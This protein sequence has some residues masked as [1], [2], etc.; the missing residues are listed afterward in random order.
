MPRAGRLPLLAATHVA[1]DLY[2]GAVPALAPYF[3]SQ[4]HYGYAAVGGVLLAGTL[5]ACVLM[6]TFGM[7]SDRYG[8][9]WMLPVG[10]LAAGLGFGLC[11]IVHSYPVTC[12]G[13]ALSGI[14]VAAYHPVAAKAAR[15]AVGES[16][17][18]MGLFSVGGNVGLALG[19]LLVA[20]VIG[21]TGLGGTGLLAL[22]GFVMALV[23]AAVSRRA[24]SGA[25]VQRP[26][27][28]AR[29]A[30]SP[31][32]DDW[33]RFR[34]LVAM[35]VARAIGSVGTGSFVAL[36][37][38]HEFHRSAVVGSLILEVFSG[39]GVA[40]TIFGGWVADRI[41]RAQTLRLAYL[42]S[43]VAMAAIIMSP[44]IELALLA[45]AVLG[46]AWF[47]PFAVQL[48]LGQD[49][50]PS[51]PGTASGVTLGFSVT[52][53]GLFTPI[54]GSIADAYGLAAALWVGCGA[55]LVGLVLSTRLANPSGVPVP[56]SVQVRQA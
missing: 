32:Q 34:I 36:Y 12:A 42:V 48:V 43:P 1:T 20:L 54:V 7:M 39:F 17:H 29:V 52:A 28:A 14:G 49:Y 37:L 35:I 26:R 55:L 53:A 23:Y 40:G 41:G 31:V 33:P 44:T 9:P 19:P 21:L 46:F 45:T 3:A 56:A 6:P 13:V 4:R 51:R 24:V 16:T 5:L 22:P 47:M 50:L 30:D 2:T 27:R 8:V 15:A 25:P 38:I 18:G 11:G 10:T